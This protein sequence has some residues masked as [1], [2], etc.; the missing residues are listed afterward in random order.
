LDSIVDLYR[1]ERKTVE[2]PVTLYMGVSGS[3]KSKATTEE[4]RS[5][6]PDERRAVRI[7]S[8]T[9]A[10]RAKAKS[11]LDFDE[12]RGFNFPTLSTFIM[13]PAS[14]T[15]V[16]DDAGKIW[17]GVLDLVILCNPLVNRVI[18][19]GD[20]AQGISRIPLRGGQ[21]E[22]MPST[23]DALRPIITKYATR[24]HRMFRL[25]A[26]TLGL[27][28]TNSAPGHITHCVG[29]KLGLPVATASPRY[30][31]VLSGAGRQAYTYESV[32]GE[33]FEE[34]VEIDATGLEGA[35]LDRTAYVALTRSKTG[36]YLRMSALDP[37][38]TIKEPPS[39]SNIINALV[40][41]LRHRNTAT[42]ARPSVLVKAAFYQHLAHCMPTL[43]WFRPV[44][45]T[46]PAEMFQFCEPVSDNWFPEDSAPVD[47]KP[48]DAEP[49]ACGPV[50][51]YIA[52]P[53]PI[54]KEF[55]EVTTA[56][57]ATD[58]FKETDFVN[59]HVHKRGDTATYFLSVSKR[60]TSATYEQNLK[61]YLTCKRKDLC[62]EY[63]KLVPNPPLWTPEKH[64]EYADRAIEM[65]CETRTW[66]D[67]CKK[68]DSI[69]PDRTGADIR[70]S[71]KNQVI[72]KAEKKD[73]VHAI[74]GQLIHEF[75]MVQTIHDG[76][77]ALF[78]MEEILGAFPKNFSFYKRLSPDDFVE[79]YQ[80]GWRVDNGA[81]SSDV[82]R[83]DVGRDA[84]VLNLD[85]HAF[86]RSKVSQTLI[87]E[88]V[89]RRLRPR[90]QH[91][92][93]K[94]MQP[95]G[96]KFTWPINSFTRAVTTS[97]V[98]NI[99]PEDHV[100]ING[101]DAAID[102]FVDIVP[103][104]DSPWEFKN[105]NGHRVEFSGFTLGGPKPEYNAEGIQ[106]RAWIL[107]SRDPSAQDKWVNYLDLMRHADPDDSCAIDVAFK[108]RSYMKPHLF[109]TFLPEKF[110]PYFPDVT[111]PSELD[112]DREIER[113][114]IFPFS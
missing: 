53:H 114:S 71:L 94:T 36:V 5:M 11:D 59:P 95:S 101:D 106:Y 82:T 85:R 56:H 83:W 70:I 30:V 14:G 6:T 57:G 44:A 108:A 51:H 12:L 61:R 39:G 109:E 107:E 102:R 86:E 55:R 35:I 46:M 45:A 32:Q 112:I 78:L 96:D 72:K 8:H 80:R 38:S 48:V 73:K 37:N 15:L 1:L 28:T 16:L 52:E 79:D 76:A 25:L 103:L 66:A 26:D 19:N 43:S 47:P 33:D 17:A 4:L 62:D 10:L 65:Y 92:P 13:E 2:I 110:R 84:G 111:F 93:Y 49:G 40:Y 89:D 42:L 100:K 63:D 18:I 68:L 3:G 50:D 41:T 29:P 21:S 75:D 113:F 34:E 60:L 31:Q 87:E 88:Y 69:D 9:Q 67:V 24:S 27:H 97:K 105:T 23:L 54:A 7:V 58:Q 74:P 90:S 81:S 22:H 104:P 99:Q 64:T 91:G 98:C 77:L 20:P